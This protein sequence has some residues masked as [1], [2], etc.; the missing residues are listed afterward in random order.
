MLNLVN[1][2]IPQAAKAVFGDV[3]GL[4]YVVDP[5]VQG[6]VTLQTPKPVSAPALVDL[7]E[8]AL[9]TNGAAIVSDGAGVYRIVPSQE[10][11]ATRGGLR[12]AGTNLSDGRPGVSTQVI[13]LQFIAAAELER[14]VKP[15][16]PPSAVLNVDETRNL[17]IA[18]GTRQEI[19]TI[20]EVVN[21]FDVDWMRGMSF[22]LYPVQSSDPQSI[23]RELDTIFGNDKA[24]PAKGIVRF[25]PNKRLRS[26][27]VISSKPQYLFKA[28]DWVRRLDQAAQGSEQ[29]LF[30]YN[31]Q[32]RSAR[33]LAL[34]L[35]KI[36]AKEAGAAVEVASA[37]PQPGAVAPKYE[38]TELVQGATDASQS[39]QDLGGGG[40]ASAAAPPPAIPFEGGDE[41]PGSNG[42][43]AGGIRIVAD[44]GNN[45]LVILCTA[46]EYRRIREA[47]ASID[48]APN[49]VLLEA[50]IAEVSLNDELRFGVKWFFDKGPASYS[51][52]PFPS[53]AVG[54]VF[55][56][57]N[58]VFS[59]A[60]VKVAIDA[61]AAI[62]NVNVVSSPSLMVLDNK[63]AVLQV[64]DEVPIATQQ[65]VGVISPD[66]PIVNSIELKDTGVILKVT[67]HVNDNGRVSLEIQQ[68]VSDVVPT[69]SS[70]IDSPTIQQRKVKTS[71][72]VDDGETLALG[73]LIQDKSKINRSQVPVLGDVPLI[74][75]LFR[76]KVDVRSRTELLILI[77]PRV[78]RDTGEARAATQEYRDRLHAV[79]P[80]VLPPNPTFRGKMRRLWQ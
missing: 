22:A 25:V 42:G 21:V 28:E 77:T 52:S 23:A 68:E 36:F 58:Y 60:N 17:I 73:G 57:F 65:A 51:L 33:E 46:V 45:A 54:A 34:V 43:A 32:N 39:R 4:N 64:G 66:A 50:T 27:L 76:S 8:A 53:G 79:V 80:H 74:G 19:G 41:A 20:L 10:A 67:P 7:F 37:G 14:I 63:T 11:A 62:T 6:L 70:G 49:Q 13:P 24:G 3:L 72:V 15:L 75:N 5:R 29:Q 78:V 47:L 38:P 26:I 35:Q 44:E 55:P 40:D 30:V 61:L 48:V 12:V 56:G 71:V 9:E 31:I 59:T 1:A 16:L 69:T 18:S 2:S